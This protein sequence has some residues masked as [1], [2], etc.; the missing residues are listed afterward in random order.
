L[1]TAPYHPRFRCGI[2][3]EKLLLEAAWA[4]ARTGGTPAAAESRTARATPP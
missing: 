1:R 4:N 2:G 3:L